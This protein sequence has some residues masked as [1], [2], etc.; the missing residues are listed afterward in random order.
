M[1]VLCIQG[2]P[3]KA[4]HKA[5]AFLQ[6]VQEASRDCDEMLLGKPQRYLNLGSGLNARFPSQAHLLAHLVSH[7]VW[8]AGCF[9]RSWGLAGRI[10]SL[11]SSL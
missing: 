2:C 3:K 9:G 6:R 5:V 7:W 8:I 10:G 1:S 11:K 4:S